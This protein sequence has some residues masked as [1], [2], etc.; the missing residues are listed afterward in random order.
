MRVTVN[1]YPYKFFTYCSSPF[2]YQYL[3]SA[4]LNV[5]LKRKLILI[6]YKP[7]FQELNGNIQMGVKVQCIQCSIRI[8]KVPWV[9][10]SQLLLGPGRS[11]HIPAT[12]CI[13]LAWE[14]GYKHFY[15]ILF[16]KGFGFKQQREIIWTPKPMSFFLK[17]LWLLITNNVVISSIYYRYF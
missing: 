15:R 3:F 17:P 8:C 12:L 13:V 11:I 7:F 16:L 10:G 14:L 1:T 4:W 5:E 6:Y 2:C 9:G